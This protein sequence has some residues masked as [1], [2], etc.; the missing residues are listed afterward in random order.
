[1]KPK[2]SG[3]TAEEIIRE[4]AMYYVDRE[5][6]LASIK[7]NDASYRGLRHY[8]A[9]RGYAK[10]SPEITG[11]Y[12]QS[13]RALYDAGQISFITFGYHRKFC[14]MADR[15]YSSGKVTSQ[16]LKPLG[17]REFLPEGKAV[18]DAFELK[19]LQGRYAV[20]TSRNMKNSA[21]Y[22][23]HY[24][25]DRS[26]SFRGGLTHST[27]SEFLLHMARRRPKSM[28]PLLAQLRVFFAYLSSAGLLNPLLINVLN[29][30][31]APHRKIYFGFS[32]EETSKML[33]ATDRRLALGKRDYAMMLLAKY[34]G[35][36]GADIINL[37][38]TDIRWHTSEIVI[39]QSKTRQPIA[40][41]LMADVGN[42][43]ADYLLCA[44][45]AS[46][47]DHV[48]LRTVHP[49]EALSYSCDIVERYAS[50]ADVARRADRPIGSHTF[51]TKT[52]YRWLR[53]GRDLNHCLPYLSTYMGHARFE[54]TAYYIHLVPEYFQQISA[55]VAQRFS[56]LIPEVPE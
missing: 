26:I 5:F 34:T 49:F 13:R 2:M 11:D 8:Y 54:E 32:E 23:L 35:L 46:S 37:K 22:F 20:K 14:D 15:Y 18:L 36:R 21:K 9:F 16:H 19:H 51:A 25:E 55:P 7:R 3:A 53:E 24:C 43:I 48:F 10:Y 38:L 17:Y 45:P 31:V 47:S 33:A 4:T 1:M 52:L 42:A 40:L 41:P 29:T 27:V 44:R 12:V 28:R 30:S 6:C 50:I 39:T 56:R